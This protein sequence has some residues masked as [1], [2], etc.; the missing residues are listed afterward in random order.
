LPNV[1]VGLVSRV[2]ITPRGAWPIEVGA[3]LWAPSSAGA[4]D[5]GARFTLALGRLSTCPAS[6]T[7][8]RTRLSAC[9]GVELGALRGDGF[10]FP[11]AHQYERFVLNGSLTGRLGFRIASPFEAAAGLAV[12]V[13]VLR[14]RFTYINADQVHTDVFRMSAVAGS[15]DLLLG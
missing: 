7:L 1:S 10:G 4:S 2:S 12:I 9:A 5:L 15:L 6:A 13:P 11:V 14:D 8:G 3:V